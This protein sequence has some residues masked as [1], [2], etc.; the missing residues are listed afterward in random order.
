MTA[1]AGR[2]APSAFLGSSALAREV[3]AQVR[4]CAESD[5]TVLIRGE[6]GTGKGLVARAIHEAS[7]RSA[8]QFTRVDCA[9]LAAAVFESELF[10]CEAGA[11]TGAHPRAGLLESG[12]S[13]TVFLDEVGEIP[14]TGQAKLL[15]ALDDRQVRRLGANR[16]VG[17]RARFV[18]ATNRP[19]Q[20]MARD[21][22][23]RSDL[24]FRL[25]V[26]CIYVP[27]LR[28][29]IEDVPAIWESFG[30]AG[31]GVAATTS[32]AIAWLQRRSWPGN[33]RELRN[34]FERARA[35]ARRGLIDAAVL[36]RCEDLQLGETGRPVQRPPERPTCTL[37]MR[38]HAEA[39]VRAKVPLARFLSVLLAA[40]VEE[41][42]GNKTA[43]ARSLGIG[44]KQLERR[45]LQVHS[46]HVQVERLG[47]G[48]SRGVNGGSRPDRLQE[49]AR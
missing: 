7:D 14:P 12:S 20:S 6:T 45:L 1:R 43:A 19:L 21:G 47:V 2:D 29:R 34:F 23:F 13:G 39:L 16:A 31:G 38:Q 8:R 46:G 15:S 4:A 25:A 41:H 10:G 32:D 49:D 27:P 22:T 9:A 44:R 24:L 36:R 26:L 48:R 11:F 30:N 40:A 18:A 33:V 42:G 37:D 35:C 5:A 3:R 17:L 28:D